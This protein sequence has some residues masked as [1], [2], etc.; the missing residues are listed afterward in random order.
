MKE[1]REVVDVDP[2]GQAESRNDYDR[3]AGGS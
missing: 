3:E 1:K 2:L